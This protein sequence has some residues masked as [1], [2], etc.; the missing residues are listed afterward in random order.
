MFVAIGL[1]IPRKIK[2]SIEAQ[3]SKVPKLP[4]T[5]TSLYSVMAYKGQTSRDF[6]F[7]TR[8]ISCF[9]DEMPGFCTRSCG[10]RHNSRMVSESQEG[11][12]TTTK[13]ISQSG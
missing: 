10:R 4:P 3:Q 5:T 12:Y 11:L 2:R 1:K 8:E 6:P 9:L 13:F 7:Y